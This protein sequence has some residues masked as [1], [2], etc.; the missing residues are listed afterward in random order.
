MKPD[1]A[2]DVL[3]SATAQTSNVDLAAG[4]IRNVCLICANREATGHGVYIDADT[5]VTA[6]ENAPESKRILAYI[7][8]PSGED[9]CE[10]NGSDRFDSAPGYF[11]KLRI[12]GDCLLGDFVAYDA[13]KTEDPE[14]FARLFEMASKTPELVNMSIEASGYFVFVGTDGEE[15]GQCPANTECVREMPSFRVSKLSAAAFVSEGAATDSLFGTL[16]K[17]FF[18]AFRSAKPAPAAA[19]P[20]APTPAAT[21]VDATPVGMDLKALSAKYTDAIRLQRA[22]ALA[23]ENAKLTL[24]DIDGVLVAEDR[25]AEIEQLKL[26]ATT[27]ETTVTNL[28]AEHALAL[29]AVQTQLA[30]ANAKV[31]AAELRAT[32]AEAKFTALE[33][34]GHV[35]AINLRSPA[36]AKSEQDLAA[37]CEAIKDPIQKGI[38]YNKYLAALRTA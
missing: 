29:A 28:R 9:Y 16:V 31:T 32:E 5:L 19:A 25:A 2:R 27:H 22:I 8:H 30:E 11:E 10:G 17:K 37:E 1:N 6:L 13:F 4:I 33:S 18:S 36:V 15:Y 3:F 34:S 20:T 24:E 14:M 35:G 38:F 26:A 7:H 23:G 21:P 12:E